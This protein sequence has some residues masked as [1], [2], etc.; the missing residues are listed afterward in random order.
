[1]PAATA[2]PT[3]LFSRAF[4]LPDEAATIA[5]GQRVAQALAFVRAN[6]AANTPEPADAERQTRA[7]QAFAGLQIHLLGDLGAGKT[8]LVRAMLHAL[9]HIGRVRSPTYTLVEPY[10]I[11]RH[12][13]PLNV[14]HFDLYRFADP[15]EW[16]D[17]GFRDY[18]GSGALCLVE[19]PQQAG[20]LLG[21]PD[22]IFALELKPAT[23]DESGA[24]SAAEADGTG[25]TLAAHAYTEIGKKCLERC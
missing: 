15:A 23:H 7:A 8:T 10:L 18:F 1:M 12:D 22:L 21:I 13:T 19:W 11:T 4:D 2:L 14:Y 5:F 17:A 25:R 3:P 6:C 20:N 9:G 16:A 24:E